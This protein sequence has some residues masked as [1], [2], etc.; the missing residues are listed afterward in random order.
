MER[1]KRWGVALATASKGLVML[2]KERL[3]IGRY[4]AR[5]TSYMLDRLQER[6]DFD[7][8]LERQFVEALSGMS[9]DNPIHRSVLDAEGI[10]RLEPPGCGWVE[11]AEV[12][13]RD[14]ACGLVLMR[15]PCP[16]S[17]CSPSAS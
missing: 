13:G 5:Y 16:L 7:P 11:R 15:V 4:D 9:Y 8:G 6:P 1:V 17:T 12:P 14:P 2:R 3:V 10:G